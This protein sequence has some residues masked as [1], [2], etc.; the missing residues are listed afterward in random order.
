M[1]VISKVQAMVRMTTTEARRRFAAALDKVAKRGQR[2]MLRRKGR[3]VAAV[4]SVDDLALLEELEDRLDAQDA[5]AAE[6]QAKARGE[7]PIPW[8]RARRALGL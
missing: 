8:D 4:V 7:K 2:I 5:I 3:D 6:A 1:R